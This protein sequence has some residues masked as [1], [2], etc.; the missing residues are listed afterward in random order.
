MFNIA[1][2]QALSSLPCWGIFHLLFCFL[3]PTGF[4][5]PFAEFW[6]FSPQLIFSFFLILEFLI[7]LSLS[8]ALLM[9]I[10]LKV[11]LYSRVWNRLWKIDY[12]TQHVPSPVPASWLTIPH[13]HPGWHY[14][15]SLLYP[16]I[17]YMENLPPHMCPPPE[18]KE[19]ETWSIFYCWKIKRRWQWAGSSLHLWMKAAARLPTSPTSP[20]AKC[21]LKSCL[22]R[23]L[24]LLF[25]MKNVFQGNYTT[26]NQSNVHLQRKNGKQYCWDREKKIKLIF[27]FY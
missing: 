2:T 22:F 5:P 4:F 8:M 12:K 17:S 20:P 15:H 14:L 7:F 23:T 13:P 9:S 21:L 25:L 11:S 19:R 1:K 18:K 26:H 6:R 10:L 3:P 24:G 27:L 16:A